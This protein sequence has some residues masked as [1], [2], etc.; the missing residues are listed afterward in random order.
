MAKKITGADRYNLMLALVGYLIHNREVSMDDLASH[1][2]VTREEVRSALVTV[3]FSGI[4]GYD[5][6]DLFEFDYYKFN[7]EGVVKL[8]LKPAIDEVPRISQRQA[9]ALSAGLNYLRDIEIFAEQT[10]VTELI[11]ILAQ[12]TT[13]GSIPEIQIVPGTRAAELASVRRAMAEQRKLEFEYHN[14]RGEIKRRIVEP[15][16]VSLEDKNITLRAFVQEDGMVKNF[17][18]D[19]M[20]GVKV[21]DEPI[22]AAAKAAEVIDANYI[23]DQT[24]TEVTVE[25]APEAH[26][27]ISQFNA[28]VIESRPD[29]TKVGIIKIG[30][31]P[32]LGRLIASY[33]GSAKVLAPQAAREL[34][35]DYAL[36]A[37]GETAMSNLDREDD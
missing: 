27:L 9:A 24:D 33:G 28:E 32:N 30:H 29:G 12:G 35:R 25:V 2:K 4:K 17:R 14:M 19:R 15:L 16:L 3:S 8:I 10:E 37:L 20:R 1:F 23:A 5:P 36:S 26:R 11:Q 31:L 13:G 18:V 21:L 7:H 22:S 6:G 34:V